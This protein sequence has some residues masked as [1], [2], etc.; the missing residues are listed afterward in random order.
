MIYKIL[1][2]LIVVIHFAWILFMLWG[3]F[4]TL[5]SVIGLCVFGSQALRCRRFMDRWI[6]RTLHLGGIAFVAL[7]AALDQYCP[8]TIW[9]YNLRRA[10]DPNLAWPG[11][12]IV[13]WIERLVYP[14]VPPLAIVIPTIGIALFTLLAYLLCPPNQIRRFLHREKR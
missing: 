12:F 5:G 4:L 11:S 8:L 9:E 6:F 3:F 2:D 1:A 14:D 10:A 7:L 13:R